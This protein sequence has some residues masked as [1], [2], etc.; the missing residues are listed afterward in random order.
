MFSGGRPRWI[1]ASEPVKEG[2]GEL[3]E[4]REGGHD[5]GEAVG[6]VAANGDE[7]VTKP[8]LA[9]SAAWVAPLVVVTAAGYGHAV[10]R[11]GSA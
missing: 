5:C 3:G 2:P 6:R 1:V 7:G 4:F 10:P 11:R 8:L 9:G